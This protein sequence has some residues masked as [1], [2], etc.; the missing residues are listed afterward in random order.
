L[1][2]AASLF[3]VPRSGLVRARRDQVLDLERLVAVDLL[4]ENLGFS[5]LKLE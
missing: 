3:V 2:P 5:N 1:T 4:K